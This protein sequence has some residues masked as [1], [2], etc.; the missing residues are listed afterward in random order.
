MLNQKVVC[1]AL[2][3]TLVVSF[4]VCVSW[5]LV[6]PA[7]L[8]M[9]EFLEMALPGFVWISAG[10]FMLGLIESFLFGVYAGLVYVPIYN[11]LSRRIGER[12]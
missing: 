2:G 6:M 8:H 9:H 1:L 7:S 3:L 4:V 12:F 5:G 11:S 10:S